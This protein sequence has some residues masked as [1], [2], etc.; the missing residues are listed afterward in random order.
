MNSNGTEQEQVGLYRA[1]DPTEALAENSLVI[2][3]FCILL[4]I[5]IKI[6]KKTKSSLEW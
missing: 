3:Y 4:P 1:T 2:N 6:Y 5:E